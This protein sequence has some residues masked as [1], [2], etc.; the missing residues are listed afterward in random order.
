[1]IPQDLNEE[2]N[3]A[4]AQER[5]VRHLFHGGGLRRFSGDE[6]NDACDNF[7]V[8]RWNGYRFD[9]R[10]HGSAFLTGDGCLVSA[11]YHP[12]EWEILPNA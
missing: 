8:L 3:G 7:H 9:V 1:M 11:M 6:P 4:V 2:T 5:L 12:E 10:G